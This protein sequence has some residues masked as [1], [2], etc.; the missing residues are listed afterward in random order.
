MLSLH[1][2]HPNFDEWTL[3]NDVC[4][5]KLVK[6]QSWSV[7]SGSSSS[8]PF[9]TRIELNFDPDVP[10]RNEEMFVVA[11]G[12][13]ETELH[14]MKPMETTVFATRNQKC[15]KIHDPIAI[16]NAMI[17]GASSSKK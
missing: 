16:T 8:T 12:T 2:M 6:D 17:C 1:S 9:Y 10:V 15:G 3:N 7:S 11:R 14:T 5:L 13:T 4:V